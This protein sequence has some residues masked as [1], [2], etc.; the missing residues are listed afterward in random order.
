MS[1]RVTGLSSTLGLAAAV[2][3]AVAAPAAQAAFPGSNGRMRL[4]L[5]RKLLARRPGVVSTAK[6]VTVGRLTRNVESGRSKVMVKL[7]KKPATRLRRL[8]DQG[9]LSQLPLNVRTMLKDGAGLS[10]KKTVR[11][12][13]RG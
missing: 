2:V 1:L 10:T 11:V 7:S 5:P 6:A 8:L 9:E 4:Q 3:T 13:L 12:K